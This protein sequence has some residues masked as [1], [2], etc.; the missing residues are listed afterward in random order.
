MN[1]KVHILGTE[2]AIVG[3]DYNDDPEF[4]ENSWDG[5]VDYEAK[6]VVYCRMKTYPGWEKKSDAAIS[7]WE[8]QTKRHELIHAFLHESGLA[9]SSLSHSAGWAK[10][11]EMV[12]WMALQFPKLLLAFQEVGC[13]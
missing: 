4:A 8:K 5:Y 1:H 7:F 9:D 12:D 3:K 6:Q 13:L 2:Y 10:N 11:E